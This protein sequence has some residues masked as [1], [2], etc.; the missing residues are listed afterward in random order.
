M[1]LSSRLALRYTFIVIACL[2]LLAGLAHH[3]FIYE[4]AKRHLLGIREL[5]EDSWSE[6][7]EVFFYA[8]IPLILGFGWWMMH[9]TLLPIGELAQRVEKIHADNLREPLPR[10]FNGDELDRLT[11]VFNAMTA[12]L[13]KSIEQIRDFSLHA[14]HELKT[15]LT[16][17]HAQ[18]ST[19]LLDE[20]LLSWR[21]RKLIE[22][23]LDEIRRLARIVDTLSLLA[24]ADAG[25]L[26]IE[27]NP[28]PL[29]KL[30]GECFEDS[31]VLAQ[32]E[33]VQVRLEAC[34]NAMVSGDRDRL[35][36]LL[37]NLTDNAIKYNRTGGSVTLSLLNKGAVAELRITNTGEEIP[38]LLISRVF[39]R[40]FRGPEAGSRAIKGTGL[41]LVIV[42]WIVESHGGTIVMDSKPGVTTTVTVTLPVMDPAVSPE[43]TPL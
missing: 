31:L 33:G 36:Q 20:D 39:D 38:P 16:I 27:H 5:P 37:L 23:Q 1:T 7:A 43:I 26:E 22:G 11:G 14:S 30:M 17:M 15:P 8:M 13:Q 42:K 40:F 9:R 34:D 18:C 35:R 24:K 6:Y 28:V 12:Q 32:P 29:H 10:T 21:E 3:E 25:L 4:P 2:L 41:G 19:A